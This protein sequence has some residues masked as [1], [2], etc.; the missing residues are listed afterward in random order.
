MGSPHLTDLPDISTTYGDAKTS[1]KTKEENSDDEAGAN[2]LAV[3]LIEIEREL[4]GKVSKGTE[5]W[6]DLAEVL[7]AELRIAA[8]RTTVSNVPAFLSEHLRRRL[9][10]VDKARAD[11]M[12]TGQPGQG[13]TAPALT[14]EEKQKCPDCAGVGFWYPEGTEKGVAKCA[15]ANL[16][17]P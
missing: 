9:W 11:E 6:E 2:R 1:F 15:H 10:K 8:A 14:S 5:R 3:R 17:R 4:T 16:K 7:I 12:A 13:S